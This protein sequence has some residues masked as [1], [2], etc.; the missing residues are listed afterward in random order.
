M[1]EL[2]SGIFDWLRDPDNRG[3]VQVI[4]AVAALVVAW[5]TG[6]LR[7]A[8]GLFRREKPE[9][10]KEARPTMT[11]TGGGVN[12]A[13]DVRG[14]LTTGVAPGRPAGGGKAGGGTTRR[15]ARR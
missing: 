8:F 15:K 13:G 6:L 1:G 3:A 12:V 11:A 4:V 7:W 5:A 10:P 2:V 9:A 14:D